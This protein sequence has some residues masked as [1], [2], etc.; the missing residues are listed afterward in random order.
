MSIIPMSFCLEEFV[1]DLVVVA[2]RGV[3]RD[4]FAQEA[5][6]EQL[7]AQDHRRECQVEVGRVGHQRVVIAHVHIVEFERTHHNHRDEA[8]QE[9]QAAQ[10]AE[11]MHRLDPKL[12]LEP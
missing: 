1:A 5:R 3:A 10:Q 12:G 8:Q 2:G 11:E 9:D 4:Q 7:G 6:E